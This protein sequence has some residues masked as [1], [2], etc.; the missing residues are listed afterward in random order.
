MVVAKTEIRLAVTDVKPVRSLLL[1][2]LL[3]RSLIYFHSRRK[4]CLSVCVC[5]YVCACYVCAV[6]LLQLPTT[7]TE[8]HNMV[9]S[10]VVDQISPPVCVQSLDA[11]SLFF[12]RLQSAQQPF[13]LHRS[14]CINELSSPSLPTAFGN[15][16]NPQNSSLVRYF[17]VRLPKSARAFTFSS[18]PGT[19]SSTPARRP[20]ASPP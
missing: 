17:H 8:L 2:G 10:W 14:T 18:R 9:F 15:N 3:H 6:F 19:E 11:S 13:V 20:S 1:A 5:V 16:E 7:L 4:L 12:R